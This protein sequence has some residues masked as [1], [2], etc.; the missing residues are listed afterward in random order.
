MEEEGVYESLI[1]GSPNIISYES[2]KTI[3][4]QMEQNICKINIGNVQGQKKTFRISVGQ[5]N[6]PISTRR[7]TG[8]RVHSRLS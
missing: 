7:R 2:T 1:I 8:L 4:D 3:I 5:F 6:F